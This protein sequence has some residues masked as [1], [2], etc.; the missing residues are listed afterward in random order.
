MSRTG[1]QRRFLRCRSRTPILIQPLD[2]AHLTPGVFHLVVEE[3]LNNA[4]GRSEMC[5]QL[6]DDNVSATSSPVALLM[7]RSDDLS[8]VQLASNPCER[9]FRPCAA[10]RRLGASR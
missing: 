7:T 6:E 8:W 4:A 5:L 9:Q 1:K 2:V 10:A 3:S